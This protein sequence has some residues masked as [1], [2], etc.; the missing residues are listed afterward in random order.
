[1]L[2]GAEAAV[3]GSKSRPRFA[4]NIHTFV[5]ACFAH[6]RHAQK[7]AEAA[8]QEAAGEKKFFFGW[9]GGGE[10]KATLRTPVVKPIMKPL[11][12]VVA[13]QPGKVDAAVPASA[14]VDAT[15]T[16]SQVI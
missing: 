8:Q 9:F 5:D 3:K 2:V 12:S 7:A 13:K 10:K 11:S 15:S 6:Q 14:G 1:M 4:V 16:V